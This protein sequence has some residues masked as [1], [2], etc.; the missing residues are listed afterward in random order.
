MATDEPTIVP[1]IH[2]PQIY[3]LNLSHEQVLSLVGLLEA[4][5]ILT[6]SKPETCNKARGLREAILPQVS[7]QIVNF[8]PPKMG[9]AN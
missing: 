5:E 6:R 8:E 9:R 1:G 4:V 3:S 2:C 7:L